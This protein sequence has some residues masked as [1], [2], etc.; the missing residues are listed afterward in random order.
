MTTPLCALCDIEITSLNDSREHIIQNA[1]GGVRKVPGVFCASCNS[2]TGSTWDAEAARQ[3][4]F[5]TLQIG[6]SRDRGD[7][8]AADFQTASGRVVRKHAD[9]HLTFPI[10]KP[11]IKAK[12][13]G[14]QIQI[15]ATTRGQAAKT[16][17]GLKRKFPKLDVDAALSSIDDSETYL[18]EPVVSELNFGGE[19][20]GRS[21]VKSALTLA[22][23]AGVEPATCNLALAYLRMP[24]GEPCFGYYYKRDLVR[25]RPT[26]CIFHCVR[27]KGH[28]TSG[29]LIGYVEL[30]GV[31]RMV[32]GL[33]DRYKGPALEV[34]YAI[35]P[36][37]GTELSL[38][39][40]LDFSEEDLRFAVGNEDQS[41]AEQ[42]QAFDFMMRLSQRRSFEREQERVTAKAYAEALA[43]LDLIPG[44]ELSVE[45]A[46]QLSREI[47]KRMM[48]FLLHRASAQRES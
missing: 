42:L 22:I 48:P 38:D 3:L 29:K 23:S 21:I 19:L 24:A 25:N 37:S 8:R 34:S 6:V 47:T 28:P 41:L 30:F 27:V 15:R 32:V 46:W 10:S 36:T 31:Y 40:D 13:E 44:Q 4:R 26:D 2:A 18:T 9:G 20:S 5:L 35:D 11:V 1:I 39:I 45:T 16:L 17:K 12:Q 14:V 7:G 33:S 43:A